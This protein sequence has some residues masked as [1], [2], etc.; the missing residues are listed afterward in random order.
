MTPRSLEDILDE[1]K[2]PPTIDYMSL[3]VIPLAELSN[4][5][6][7]STAPERPKLPLPLACGQVEGHETNVLRGLHR[8]VRVLTVERP[9]P[10][11]RTIL[12]QRDMVHACDFDFGEELW[13]EHSQAS[14]LVP[15][16]INATMICADGQKTKKKLDLHQMMDLKLHM[17]MY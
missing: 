10:A 4:Q 9:D 2:A 6:P 8:K 12:L 3:D 11:A 13:I 15:R 14:S 17:E 16:G 1:A 5:C 7:S